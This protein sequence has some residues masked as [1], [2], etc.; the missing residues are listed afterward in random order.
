MSPFSISNSIPSRPISKSNSKNSLLYFFL[1]HF[2]LITLFIIKIYLLTPVYSQLPKLHYLKPPYTRAP[3]L[4]SLFK[5]YPLPLQTNIDSMLTIE[6][7]PF[8]PKILNFLIHTFTLIL[9][10]SYLSWII[11]YHWNLHFL[12]NNTSLGRHIL[13]YIFSGTMKIFAVSPLLF[14]FLD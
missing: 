11:I 2:T 9:A 8:S 13:T 4:K 5:A 7:Y 10:S 12:Q 14:I 6:E 3:S 1:I